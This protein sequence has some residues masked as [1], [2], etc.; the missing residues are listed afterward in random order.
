[1]VEAVNVA[2]LP[3]SLHILCGVQVG[4]VGIVCHKDHIEHSVVVTKAGSPHTLSVN[5]LLP[6]QA[7]CRGGIQLIVH[8]SCMLPVNQVVGAQNLAARHEMHAGAYHVI[9]ILHTDDIR[10]RIIH[11]GNR[12]YILILHHMVVIIAPIRS[13]RCRL[14]AKINHCML[15]HGYGKLQP[16]GIHPLTLRGYCRVG[17]H[18][19]LPGLCPGRICRLTHVMP[20]LQG[21]TGLL[22]HPLIFNE[23][24]AGHCLQ[25]DLQIQGIS[26]TFS[27]VIPGHTPEFPIRSPDNDTVVIFVNT[28]A[29]LFLQLFKESKAPEG[30][31]G[32]TA[33]CHQSESTVEGRK[34]H[35]LFL[36]NVTEGPIRIGFVSISQPGQLL[37]NVCRIL[38]GIM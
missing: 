9:G 4:L 18:L 36:K 17:C 10:I 19:Q 25:T 8:I 12:V 32:N 15:L 2:L 20:Y 11:G 31:L 38:I 30:R 16:S 14:G 1:M 7:L 28:A 37:C 26:G 3:G 27:G 21:I 24:L 34:R 23:I 33:V 5:V 13:K 22:I 29:F 35:A 6:L